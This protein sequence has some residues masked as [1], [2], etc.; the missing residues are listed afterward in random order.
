MEGEQLIMSDR[1]LRRGPQLPPAGAAVLENPEPFPV[2]ARREVTARRTPEGVDSEAVARVPVHVHRADVDANRA[3]GGAPQRDRP[4]LPHR[5]SPCRRP[6]R[7]YSPS[8]PRRQHLSHRRPLPAPVA[9]E[10]SSGGWALFGGQ[11]TAEERRDAGGARARRLAF[12][13]GVVVG[14]GVGVGVGVDVVGD[15][16]AGSVEL[17]RRRE[18]HLRAHDG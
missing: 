4:L 15:P 8:T 10:A 16:A 1:W 17:R 12:D 11:E 9:S 13:V 6:R 3:T 7:L 5:R 14:V 18:I 2:C